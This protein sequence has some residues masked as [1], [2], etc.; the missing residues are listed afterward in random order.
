MATVTFYQFKTQLTQRGQGVLVT[1]EQSGSS[2]LANLKLISVGDICTITA[3]S[4][5]GTVARI[6]LSGLSFV[7]NPQDPTTNL[8]DNDTIILQEN[9]QIDITT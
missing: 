9:A 1:L 3:S 6:D 8:S 7:I 5:I 4:L 2:N